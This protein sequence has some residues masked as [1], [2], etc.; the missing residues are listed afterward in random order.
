M[1][2][3]KVFFTTFTRN[4]AQDI[5]ENLKTL[6]GPTVMQRIDVQNLDAWVHGFLRK[7]QYEYTIV[8][9]RRKGPAADAWNLALAA[10]DSSL[11]L[12]PGFYEEEFENVILAQGVTTRDEY[13]QARRKGRGTVLNRAKRDAIWPMFEDYRAAL[14]LRKLKE[15]DDAYRDAASLLKDNPS[16]YASIIV[17][18]TQDFGPQ[19]LKLL[20]AMAQPGKNDLFFVG[21][22]HQRIYNRHRASMSACGIDIRGRGRKLYLNYRTTEEIRRAAV[23]LLEG[24]EVDDL[25]DGSDEVRKYKSV[26]RG[27][28]PAFTQVQ[29]LENAFAKAVEVVAAALGTNRS[30][31]VMVPSKHE[32]QEVLKAL[33]SAGISSTLI[34]PSERDRAESSAARVA[35]MHRA[36]GLEFDEVV[37]IAKPVHSPVTTRQFDRQRL[38]YV[39]LTRAKR[40]ATVIRLA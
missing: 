12:P 1:E 27:P 9:D 32:A 38:E 6:C 37:L 3:Q 31:C 29:H 16:S 33:K 25:D 40:N 18:E 20:R 2:G 14:T 35:T 4:L 24:C 17:D 36:K 22:G 10:A 39:A 19:A 5:E 13:R 7:H 15:V 8:F 26:S 23:A 30:V 11:G 28:E 21:D 34:G